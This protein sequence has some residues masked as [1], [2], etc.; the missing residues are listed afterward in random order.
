M[1]DDQHARCMAF[2]DEFARLVRRYIPEYVSEDAKEMLP[3]MQDMTSCYSPYVWDDKFKPIETR[4]L[5]DGPM[6][7][8]EDYEGCDSSPNPSGTPQDPKPG[9]GSG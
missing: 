2:A 8:F 6:G 7:I 1:N 3:L 4:P 9:S 5:Y